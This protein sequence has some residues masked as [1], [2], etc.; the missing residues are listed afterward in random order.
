MAGRAVGAAHND[1]SDPKSSSSPAG[2]EV[3]SLARIDLVCC[4]AEKAATDT[5]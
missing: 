2:K 3:S 1:V 4:D 5:D